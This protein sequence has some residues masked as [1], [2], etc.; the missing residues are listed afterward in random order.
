ME[1][2]KIISVLEMTSV[3]KSQLI[4]ERIDGDIV[5][6]EQITAT[7]GP[8]VT[9]I[10]MYI[11]SVLI[12]SIHD[13]RSLTRIYIN[14]PMTRTIPRITS[15]VTEGVGGTTMT[16]SQHN[17]HVQKTTNILQKNITSSGIDNIIR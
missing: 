13:V 14:L 9:V 5:T 3:S 11:V 4:S 8:F 12:P 6:T 15:C 17:T 2:G 10:S 7:V 1:E 16:T